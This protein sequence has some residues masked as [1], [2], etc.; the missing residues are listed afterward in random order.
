MNPHRTLGQA[1]RQLRALTPAIPADP[2]PEPDGDQLAREVDRAFADELAR[3]RRFR[4]SQ[5]EYPDPAGRPADWEPAAI[6]NKPNEE[7]TFGDLERLGR[8]DPALIT[9]RWEAVKQTARADLDRGYLAARA[10]EY[11]GGSAWER[12]CFLA[13]RDRLRRAW[14]PRDDTEA[15][16]IDELT[17]YETARRWW[18]GVFGMRS[19]EPQAVLAR[20]REGQDEDRRQSAAEATAEAGRMVERLQRLSQNV[21]RLLLSLRRGPRTTIFQGSGQINV[22]VEQQMNVTNAQPLPPTSL[23]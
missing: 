22:G 19:R 8:I 23:P 21:L 11:Q 4:D 12:A 5:P 7:V 2:P 3:Y 1:R 13:V 9:A 10:L 20:R 16:L 17:Q 18:V 6:D 14:R 15:M